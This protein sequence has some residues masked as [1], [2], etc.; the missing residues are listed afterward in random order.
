LLAEPASVSDAGV[1]DQH[2]DLHAVG[3]ERSLDALCFLII[4]A[5]IVVNTAIDL[6]GTSRQGRMEANERNLPRDSRGQQ[7]WS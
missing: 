7:R 4:A 5:A 1:V 3:V 2:S 6:N